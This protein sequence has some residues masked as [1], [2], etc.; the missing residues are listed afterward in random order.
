MFSHGNTNDP[1]DYAHT[2]ERIAAGGFVVAAPSHTNNTQDDTRIDFFN[3]LAGV[4]PLPCNDGRPGPCSR[5]DVPFSMADRVRDVSSVLS[6]LPGWFG[7]RVDT[8]RAGRSRAL[9]RHAQR[10]RRR[11]RERR[12]RASGPPT[13]GTDPARCW[14]LA[15]RP[16]FQAVMG[17]AIGQQPISLGVN[18]QAIRVP[19]LLVSADARPDVPAVGQLTA[20]SGT[21]R[22]P[23]RTSSSCRSRTRSTAASTRPTA[24]RCSPQDGSPRPT[25]RGALLD[26]NTFDRIVTSPNSGWGTDY[27]SRSELCRHRAAHAYRTRRYRAIDFTPTANVPASGLDTDAVKEQ[28]AATA[29]EFFG[30]KLARASSGTVGGTV[31]AT[32]AL[33]LGGAA[34]LA[35]SCPA[36]TAPTTGPPPRP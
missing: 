21:S 17:M 2:L 12:R 4:T 14:P 23:T 19:T 26:K 5:L 36:W 9:A 28:M 13:C 15:A 11:R 25:R 32:L 29:I 35:R 7:T 16:R 3:T 20:R 34:S 18:Y 24:T 8:A 27:C 1:I 31:P 10:A 22:A 6:A 30:A 33:T